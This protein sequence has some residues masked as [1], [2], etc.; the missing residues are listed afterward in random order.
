MKIDFGADECAE[1][2]NSGQSSTLSATAPEYR[3]LTTLSMPKGKGVREIQQG[4]KPRQSSLVSNRF[5][6]LSLVSGTD[7][8]EGEESD[9]S[10]AW[11]ATKRS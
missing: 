6:L 2:W 1:P 4:N 9:D 8:D 5:D 11:P 10:D 7:S 3:A